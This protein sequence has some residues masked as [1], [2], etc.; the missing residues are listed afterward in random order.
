MAEETG[1]GAVGRISFK[2][3]TFDRYDRDGF[4]Y[5]GN[6]RKKTSD[7]FQVPAR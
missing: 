1:G 3:A 7:V 6:G 4:L 5:I 2:V